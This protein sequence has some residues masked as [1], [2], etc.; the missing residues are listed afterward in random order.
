MLIGMPGLSSVNPTAASTYSSC[1]TTA[2]QM[3]AVTWTNES[4]WKI[5]DSAL[6]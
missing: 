3:L 6:A 5:A 1:S 2:A 4:K